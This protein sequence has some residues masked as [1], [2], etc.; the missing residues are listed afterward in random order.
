MTGP[1]MAGERGFEDYLSRHLAH[2]GDP[3]RYR[4]RRKRQLIATYRRFL[5]ESRDAELLE[6]GPG[7]GQWLEALRVDLG[8]TRA[9]AVDIS[10]EVVGFCDRILPGSTTQVTDTVGFLSERPERYDRVFAFHVL[11]HVPRGE[12]LPLLRAMWTALK[13]GG[14]CVVEVPN[15][16]N[17]FV[18][19]YLRYADL[20]H[21]TGFAE[22][23]LRQALEAGGFDDVRCF[24]ERL[25]LALPQDLLAV[26]FRGSMQWLMRMFYRGYQMPVPAVL[27]PALCATARRPANVRGVAPA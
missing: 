27:T 19:A 26:A 18:G 9:V 16:A 24:E 5:P 12:L 8:F 10:A 22:T 1:P 25:H 23:S 13:P 4:A 14:R 2:L 15:M 20:T 11:E 7:Y 6:I 21:E 17:P 3:E